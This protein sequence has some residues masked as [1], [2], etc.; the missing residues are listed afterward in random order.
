MNTQNRNTNMILDD[1]NIKEIDADFNTVAFVDD[2]EIELDVQAQQQ[3]ASA[4]AE[5]EV[6]NEN[7]NDTDVD[8]DQGQLQGQQQAQEEMTAPA[9][10]Q[11]PVSQTS[12]CNSIK[13]KNRLRDRPAIGVSNAAIGSGWYRILPTPGYPGTGPSPR[14]GQIHCPVPNSFGTRNQAYPQG[15]EL[16]NHLLSKTWN[17]K[18]R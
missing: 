18:L 12:L 8:T 13:S 6:E 14:D 16:G 3:D 15:P 7:K 2:A 9:Q 10:L 11:R 5:V 1:I 17:M 4:E